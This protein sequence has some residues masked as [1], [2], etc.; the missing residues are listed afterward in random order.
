MNFLSKNKI[1]KIISNYVRHMQY[2]MIF[3]HVNK[4]KQF[5]LL[6]SFSDLRHKN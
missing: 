2:I 1:K 3:L 5:C 6:S 4:T